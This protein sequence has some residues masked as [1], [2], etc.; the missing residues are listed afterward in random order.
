VSPQP[1]L[2]PDPQRNLHNSVSYDRAIPASQPDLLLG[3]S[4]ANGR[5]LLHDLDSKFSSQ[6][7]LLKLLMSQIDSLDKQ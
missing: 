7:R 6:D 1:I 4:P 2:H 5:A 3:L